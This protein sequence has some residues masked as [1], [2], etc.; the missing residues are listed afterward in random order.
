MNEKKTVIEGEFGEDYILKGM[1]S[2][3]RPYGNSER[4]ERKDGNWKGDAVKQ[5]RRKLGI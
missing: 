1:P 4:R 3:E 2:G 5:T